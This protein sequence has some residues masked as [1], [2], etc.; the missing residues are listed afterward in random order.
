MLGK[1]GK[2]P[3]CKGFMCALFETK[4]KEEDFHYCKTSRGI[5]FRSG[6]T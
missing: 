2:I 1:G 5:Y 6:T 4:V 3:S